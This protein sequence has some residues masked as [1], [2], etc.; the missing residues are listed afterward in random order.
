M[1][2]L[3][4]ILLAVLT[5]WLIWREHFRPTAAR[6]FVRIDYESHSAR[7]GRRGPPAR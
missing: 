7:R 5:G 1:I 3:P 6:R 4:I 2:L